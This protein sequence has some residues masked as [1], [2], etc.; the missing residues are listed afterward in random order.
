MSS[1][2]GLYGITTLIKSKKDQ[3]GVFIKFRFTAKII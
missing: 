2:N 1:Y 3:Q